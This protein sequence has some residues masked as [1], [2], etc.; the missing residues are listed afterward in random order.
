[1]KKIIIAGMILVA[2]WL[3]V[4]PPRAG[5]GFGAEALGLTRTH[6]GGGVTVKVTYLN[7]WDASGPRF[8]VAL[9]THSVNLDAY[10]L[11]HLSVVRDGTGAAYE[12]AR[13][14]SQ[15]SGHHRSVTLSF[16]AIP[17]STRRVELVIKDVAGVGERLFYWER[18]Q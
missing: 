4:S 14:E 10:D 5:V 3:P 6:S 2:G 7:P 15:G 1:M 16:P 11:K 9:D 18:S 17:A 8:E 12:A 13:A